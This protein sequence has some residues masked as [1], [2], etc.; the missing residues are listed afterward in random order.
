LNGGALIYPPLNHWLWL[1]SAFLLGSCIGSFLNVVIYRLP[2]GL[3]VNEPRRSFCPHCKV[4]IP[5]WLNLP[6]VSWLWLRGKCKACGAPISFR[7]FAVELLTG[8]LFAAVW[9]VF[10]P[11]AP[12]P[13]VVLLWA[14]LALLVAV[15]FIDAEH[16]IIPVGLTWAGT[17]L[18]LV[19]CALWP[20]LPVLAGEAGTWG[21]GLMQGGLGWVA[22]FVGLGIVVELGKLAFGKKELKFAA[23]VEWFLREPEADTDPMCFVIDGQSTAW[24]D[25][26]YRKTDRL[27]VEATDIR[28]DGNS[29]GGGMLTIRE[30]EICLPD[31]KVLRL[32][33]MKSLDGTATRTVIPREAMG[34]GDPHLLGMIGAFFGWTG[35]VFALFSGCVL[36]L[37]AALIGRIGF[38]K[39]LP[40]GPFLALGAGV[41]LFGGWKLW[42]WYVAF[43]TPFGMP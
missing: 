1:L 23:P 19:A 21:L 2:L 24:W 10:A 32:S 26:F 5:L 43:L 31:G 28:V 12:V 39:P 42:A 8:A 36:A 30:E 4:P 16:M 29:V 34:M 11:L 9:A 14:M 33:K 37:I 35:V 13:V 40:F 3:S 20:Q 22:G 25:I 17:G 7:Y 27:L 38:G 18:G 41:W 15:S 6:L